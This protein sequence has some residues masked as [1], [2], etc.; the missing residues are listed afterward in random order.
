MYHTFSVDNADSLEEIDRF[1]L[2][3]GEELY[4]YVAGDGAS[5]V[6]DI[7]SGTGFFTKE[8]APHVADVF[9]IDIQQA[10]HQYHK[11]HREH[12]T[13]ELITA[14][15]TTIPLANDTIQTAY[16]TMTY[17]EYATEES[18]REIQR[19]LR[20]DGQHVIIDWSSNGP[21]DRGPPADERF[22]LDE[23][24]AH[25]RDRGFEVETAKNRHRTFLL[26]ANN[27]Q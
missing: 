18:L 3:S 5:T 25:H 7:G 14:T 19:V 16:S 4:S 11:K 24:I 13:A 22:S 23:A 12:V 26:V 15:A 17:H 10:M 6:L 1:Q 21:G 8:I 9:A 20:P 2:C 27:R